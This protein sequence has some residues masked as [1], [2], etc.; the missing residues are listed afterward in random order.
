MIS[1]HS[2]QENTIDRGEFTV[3]GDRKVVVK[4]G[5]KAVD[6]KI[7]H[8]HLSERPREVVPRA[9]QVFAGS[10]EPL[11]LLRGLWAQD[12]GEKERHL[13]A[14]RHLAGLKRHKKI[15]KEPFVDL[16]WWCGTWTWH[17][18]GTITSLKAI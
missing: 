15:V 3:E 17:R 7:Q 1:S 14:A 13:V 9:S 11:A 18:I 5:E 16:E 6:H 2:E 12:V 8:L 10:A 4:L